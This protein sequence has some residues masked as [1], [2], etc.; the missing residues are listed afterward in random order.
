MASLPSRPVNEISLREINPASIYA[1]LV[2]VPTILAISIGVARE[3]DQF[4]GEVIIW[5]A[6]VAAAELLPVPA[7]RGMHVSLGFPLLMAVG[8]LYPPAWAGAIALIG[9]VDPVEFRGGTTFLKAVF[10]RSQV[11]L[12]VLLA[13]GTF[14]A[15]ASVSDPTWLVIAAT[16][17]ASLVDYLT[18]LTLVV[19]ATG[20][21]YRTSICRWPSGYR[22]SMNSLL[23]TRA[24]RLWVPF[25][26]SCLKAPSDSGPFLL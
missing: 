21:M 8:I 15:L 6:L 23:A 22:A 1:V 25:W 19:I 7:W 20:L 4:N 14:H 11:A 9:S 10:N 13:S 5:V 26:R 16:L 12:A 17:A 24:C 3:L 18:N 2:A